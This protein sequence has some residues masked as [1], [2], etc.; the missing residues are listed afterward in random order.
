[1]FQFRIP[2]KQLCLKCRKIIDRRYKEYRRLKQRAYMHEWR[3]KNPLGFVDKRSK[4][5]K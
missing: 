3:L 4:P 2:K 5:K 1:M